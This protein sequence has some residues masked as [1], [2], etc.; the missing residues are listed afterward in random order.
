MRPSIDDRERANRLGNVARILID[1]ARRHQAT[2]SSK[3]E[4]RPAEGNETEQ[5]SS[6]Q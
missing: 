5:S 4:S 6:N 1:L 2:E 3:D